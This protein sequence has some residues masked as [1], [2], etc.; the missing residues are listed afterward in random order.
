MMS[1]TDVVIST[2]IAAGVT[3]FTRAMPFLFFTRRNP[4]QIIIYLQRY[5]P[6]MTMVILVAYCLKD[7]SWQTAPYGLPAVV[8][9]IVTAALHIWRGNALF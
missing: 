3:F 1:M 9:V 6:P 7:I 5:I 4:P 8:G 2:F